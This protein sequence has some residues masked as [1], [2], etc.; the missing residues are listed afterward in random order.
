M[1]N[2]ARSKVRREESG[3]QQ[4]DGHSSGLNGGKDR[5]RNLTEMTP[6]PELTPQKIRSPYSEGIALHQHYRTGGHA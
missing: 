5:S 2:R 6:V 4:T 3:K 1:Y